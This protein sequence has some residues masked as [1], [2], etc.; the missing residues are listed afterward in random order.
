MVKSFARWVLVLEP[1][2][3]SHTTDRY[4]GKSTDDTTSPVRFWDAKIVSD[5]PS[6]DRVIENM[7]SS[8]S[9]EILLSGRYVAFSPPPLTMACLANLFQRRRSNNSGVLETLGSRFSYDLNSGCMGHWFFLGCVSDA[10]PLFGCAR[11]WF[12]GVEWAVT[13]AGQT[14]RRVEGEIMWHHAPIFWLPIS[15]PDG[16]H[17]AV[18]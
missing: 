13:I 15:T 2:N 8:L 9:A 17:T 10:I 1:F 4:T 5:D 6:L 12:N 14:S 11:Q 7:S 16:L 3:Q 18:Q